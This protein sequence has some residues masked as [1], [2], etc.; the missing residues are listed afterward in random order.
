[1]I[2]KDES[3]REYIAR[4]NR[5][6]DYIEKH[7]EQPLNLYVLAEVANFS[8]FHFHRIFTV[9][10]GET[11]N[12][13]VQRIRLE[14]AAIFLQ[15]NGRMTI[16][17]IADACGFGSLSLFSR[18]FRAYFNTTA[19]EY[20]RQ[21]RGV[22]VK[23]GLRYSK[24]GQLLSKNV[25]PGFDFETHLC[26]VKL[27]QIIFMDTKIEIKEMPEMQ[28]VYVRHTGEF[29]LIGNAYGKLMKWAGPRGLLKFP[30][31]KTVTL[32]RDDPS[33]TAVEKV[34]QDA[35]ITVGGD[36]KVDGEIGKD[37]IPAVKCAVGRFQIDE[38][39]F[40]KAWNTVCVWLTESGY[41]PCGNCYEL[42][43]NSVEEDRHRRFDVE[44]C[45][46]VK[47]L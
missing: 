9:I 47:P 42:Y 23:N 28:V 16:G 1:M 31:T 41:Q 18:S 19:K 32:Y 15:N 38:T 3:R 45:I 25:Q 13:Y 35:C 5:V 34:R 26:S 44:I 40:E 8:Q 36:V 10:T 20:R 39:G 11:P 7:L 46:P 24:N 17:E 43:H 37:V 27:N 29:N 22:Y 2:S 12:D 30:E 21:E 14:R 33:V 4:I 6:M